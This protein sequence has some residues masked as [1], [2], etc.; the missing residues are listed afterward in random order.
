MDDGQNNKKRSRV[1]DSG[2]IS[3]QKKQKLD[4]GHC[5]SDL[6]DAVST[7]DI[8]QVEALLSRGNVN[9]VNGD[10]QTSLLHIAI[11]NEHTDIAKMLIEF[12]ANINIQ[13]SGGLTPLHIAAFNGDRD[14]VSLLLDHKVNINC[15][16]DEMWTPLHYAAAVDNA[17]I[18]HVLV[19]AGAKIEY[20]DKENNTPLHVAVKNGCVAAVKCLLSFGANTRACTLDQLTALHGAA[21]HNHVEVIKLLL[22]ANLNLEARDKLNRTPLHYA[23]GKCQEEAM[24]A[25]IKA[26]A[27]IDTIDTYNRTSFDYACDTESDETIK[28]IDRLYA[29]SKAKQKPGTVYEGTEKTCSKKECSIC[30]EE[31]FS[32]VKLSCGHSLCKVCLYNLQDKVRQACD[33]DP[34]LRGDDPLMHELC[35]N[36]ANK[37]P[38][39]RKRISR[40]LK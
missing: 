19:K 17:E 2:E 30:V 28:C 20:L 38:F 22:A 14:L 29:H 37:C 8:K 12:G 16:C 23:A 13:D 7:A 34:V 3:P 24:E 6:R 26:G 25:L 27:D 35:I 1:G 9:D 18:I 33:M 39:C 4:E 10:E 36:G 15:C 31:R 32:F 40:N 11:L 21:F 5:L